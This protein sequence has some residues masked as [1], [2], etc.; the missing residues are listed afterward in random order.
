MAMYDYLT[1]PR[2]TKVPFMKLKNFVADAGVSKQELFNCATKFSVVSVAESKQISLDKL[3]NEIG[4]PGS[5][6][7]ATPRSAV[8][9]A[10]LA[11]R[12]LF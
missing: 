4:P 8:P 2:L 9:K 1:D 7:A 3:L 5:V 12:Y 10:I 11:S 6:P